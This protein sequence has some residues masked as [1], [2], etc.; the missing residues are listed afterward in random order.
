MPRGSLSAMLA[1][2]DVF[3]LDLLE[4]IEQM[5]TYLW[6]SLVKSDC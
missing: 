1:Y 3:Y 6:F 4:G 5:H 2:Y